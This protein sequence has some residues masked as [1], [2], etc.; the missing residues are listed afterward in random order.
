MKKVWSG[1]VLLPTISASGADALV[2]TY[3]RVSESHG[4]LVARIRD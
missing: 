2:D 4:W 1:R 3:K